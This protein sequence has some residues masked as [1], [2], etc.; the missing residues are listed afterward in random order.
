MALTL[1]PRWAP[2]LVWGSCPSCTDV[3]QGA[4][5]AGS[6]L[7]SREE[8]CRQAPG[9]QAESLRPPTSCLWCFSD[10]R[11][12]PSRPTPTTLCTDLHRGRRRPTTCQPWVHTGTE[13]STAQILQPHGQPVLR[14]DRAR[15]PRS[16]RAHQPAPAPEG[17]A[18]LTSH[19]PAHGDEGSWRCPGR[20]PSGGQACCGQL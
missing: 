10:N 8:P 12:L 19:F 18:P 3:E 13:Q 1:C 15:T 4:P 16:P 9:S 7:Q 5:R 11:Q 20:A 17:E 14:C 2:S 6:C